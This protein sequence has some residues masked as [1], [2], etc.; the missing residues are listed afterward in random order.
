MTAAEAVAK[1]PSSRMGGD[2]DPAN[3]AVPNE[4]KELSP[5]HLSI[6]ELKVTYPVASFTFSALNP[7]TVVSS[8]TGS[9]MG[10]AR[11]SS[12][13]VHVTPNIGAPSLAL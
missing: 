7:S 4:V 9:S 13:I 8:A 10:K 6:P 12:L 1:I 3:V 11:F 5:L 2:E